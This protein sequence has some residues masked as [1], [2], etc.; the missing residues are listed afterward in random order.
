MA[1]KRRERSETDFYHIFQRGVNRFD[2][3]ED[4]DDREAYVKRMIDC[5]KK[6]EVEIHAWCLMDNHTHLLLRGALESVSSMMRCLGS[7]YA[8]FF[9]RRH[10][11]SG[12]L[13]GSRFKSRCV[14]HED[15]LLSTVRYI[16][17]NPVVHDKLALYG[18][19]R[20]SSFSEYLA[21]SSN[22]C[23]TDLV[24][25]LFG[26]VRAFVGFHE[27][28]CYVE[29]HLDT[30][31]AGPMSDSMA[32]VYANNVLEKAGAGV[33][34]AEIGKL[35]REQRNG[36]IAL[37]RIAVGC[38]IRQIQRLTSLASST[39]RNAIKT[40]DVSA[41]PWVAEGARDYPV[42]LLNRPSYPSGVSGTLDTSCG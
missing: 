28:E 9:N 32:R 19:Y 1:T 8:R 7:W 25:S 22:T 15:Y 35:K 21:M 14:E 13:F 38:S 17:R 3:F 30:D 11:R 24:L 40:G 34:A 31:T 10:G 2:I 39:I 6:S 16:H 4:D 23:T 33:S 37:I 36:A 41:L 29:R 20:W 18:E 12:A 42:V 5:S 27:A 26:S